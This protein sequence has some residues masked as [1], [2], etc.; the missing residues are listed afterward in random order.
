M[1]DFAQRASWLAAQLV[2]LQ[3]DM[4]AELIDAACGERMDAVGERID[5]DSVR[6]LKAAVDQTRHFLWFFLQA[7]TPNSDESERTL[8]L[9]RQMAQKKTALAP[10][11]SLTMDEKLTALTEYAIAHAYDEQISN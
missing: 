11:S 3:N 8:Q 9:L 5:L 10:R 1:K 6:D 4:N 2:S 7:V